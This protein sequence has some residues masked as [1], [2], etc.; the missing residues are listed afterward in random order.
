MRLRVHPLP[1][2]PPEILALKGHKCPNKD[3]EVDQRVLNNLSKRRNEARKKSGAAL[4]AGPIQGV[5][6]ADGGEP[7]V[8]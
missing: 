6:K 2:H 5:P 3:K 8:N 7:A 4:R 1:E